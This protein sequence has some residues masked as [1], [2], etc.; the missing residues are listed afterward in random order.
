[1]SLKLL[2]ENNNTNDDICYYPV[3][4]LVEKDFNTLKLN[5]KIH[6]F[7]RSNLAGHNKKRRQQ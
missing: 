3:E 7:T 1:M 2:D 5:A 6:V 4:N